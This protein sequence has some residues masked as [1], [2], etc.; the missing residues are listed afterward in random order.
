MSETK[1][2]PG[3]WNQSYRLDQDGM[4]NTEVYDALGKTI[5]TLAWHPVPI[6]GGWATDRDA[7]ARL[8]AASP[9]LYEALTV[10]LSNVG[11]YELGSSRHQAINIAE[12]A[13]TRARGEQP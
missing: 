4:Y 3:P 1:W 7:N 9:D 10:L 12:T 2:T 13:L 8:I 11:D 6:K 5:A